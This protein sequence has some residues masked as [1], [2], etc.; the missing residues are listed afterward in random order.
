MMHEHKSVGEKHVLPYK[1]D[2]TRVNIIWYDDGCIRFRIFESPI[3]V[4]ELY[5]T[6]SKGKPSTILIAPRGGDTDE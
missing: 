5:M 1:N 3:E 4:R 2:L 6:S